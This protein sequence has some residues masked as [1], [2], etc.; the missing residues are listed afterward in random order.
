MI[1]VENHWIAADR[2]VAI[3]MH[4]GRDYSVTVVVDGMES[5]VMRCDD[6]ESQYKNVMDIVRQIEQKL[7]QKLDRCTERR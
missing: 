7:E 5:I 6:A 2:I 1:F 3:R 4:Q